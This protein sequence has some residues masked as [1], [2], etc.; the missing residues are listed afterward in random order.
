MDVAER[1]CEVKVCGSGVRSPYS[2]VVEH[3]L[4][5]RK[6][7]SS[8]LPGGIDIRRPRI[9]EVVCFLFLITRHS[10]DAVVVFCLTPFDVHVVLICSF[11][12]Q[13]SFLLWQS[14]AFV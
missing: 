11:A 5:K 6:V 13:T 8:I 9:E 12:A 2:S 4:S 14:F 1:G 10:F 7:G 3:P